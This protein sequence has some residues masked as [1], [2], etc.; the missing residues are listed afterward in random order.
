MAWKAKIQQVQ[1]NPVFN[2]TVTVNVEFSDD[3]DATR[4]FNKEYKLVSQHFSDIGDFDALIENELQCLLKF[5]NTV[6]IIKQ[7]VGASEQ[8]DMQKAPADVLRDV[9]VAPTI[10]EKEDLADEGL[11]VSE[12]TVD[13]DL[14]DLPEDQQPVKPG[15][16]P[17]KG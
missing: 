10:I 5:D 1:N 16:K 13:P 6:E 14:S 17:A 2:D 8:I 12:V 7:R 3:Q 9:D 15:I 4:K 11:Q